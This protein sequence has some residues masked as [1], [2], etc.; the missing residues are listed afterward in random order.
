[1]NLKQLRAFREVV[2]TGSVSEAARRLHRSQPAISAIIATLEQELGIE[3]FVRRGMRL[4][5]LPEAQFLYEQANEILSR[6]DNAERTMK[7]IRRLERGSLEIVSMP[8][9]SVFL[10]PHL[11]GEF[12]G[13]RDQIKIS[14]ITKSSIEVVQVI[15]AQ[16]SDI[17]FADYDLISGHLSGLVEHQTFD[18]DCYCALRFDDPLAKLQTITPRDLEGKPMATLYEDHPTNR[19]TQQAFSSLGIRMNP[20]FQ[21]QYF[22]ALFAFIERGVAYSIVDRLTIESYLLQNRS[23]ARPIVFRRF[24]PAVYLKTTI[25]SPTHRP[26]SLLAQ[27]FRKSFSA[28]LESILSKPVPEGFSA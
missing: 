26:L 24:T 2:S 20:C 25:I 11:I 12:L 7:D 17:G 18:F 19:Q 9:P 1:L 16:N 5:P 3:L 13:A 4:N 22:V 14:L 21:A 8:G 23:V 6:V 15:S 10:L 27:E 28:S